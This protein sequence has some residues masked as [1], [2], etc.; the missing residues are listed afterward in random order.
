MDAAEEGRAVR[1]A[2]L[3]VSCHTKSAVNPL[4]FIRRTASDTDPRLH[5]PS[6]VRKAPKH[7]QQSAD[8]SDRSRDSEPLNCLFTLLYL[9]RKAASSRQEL[10]QPFNVLINP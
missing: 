5:C 4:S 8:R 6:A 1:R 7:H 2:P 9:F 3:F 10:K